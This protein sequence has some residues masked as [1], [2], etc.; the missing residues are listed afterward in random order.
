MELFFAVITACNTGLIGDYDD[1]V[2]V[3]IRCTR[4]IKNTVDEI[5]IVSLM[6]ITVVVIDYAITV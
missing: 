6:H 3:L 1:F 4:Q 5:K 2:V